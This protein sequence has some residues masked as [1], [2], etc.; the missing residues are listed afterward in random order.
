MGPAALLLEQNPALTPDQVKAR[1]MRTAYKVFPQF[2]SISD[3]GT[4]VTFYEQFDAFTVDA[5]Y[6]DIQAELSNVDVPPAGLLATSPTAY[7]DSASQSV[8]FL[9]D[10]SAMWGSSAV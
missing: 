1:L 2:S 8:Y 3:P 5:G 9:N 10:T 7:F 6:L 4:G